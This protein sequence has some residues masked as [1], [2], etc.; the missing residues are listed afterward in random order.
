MTVTNIA[1]HY[2][3]LDAVYNTQ[4]INCPCQVFNLDE[5]GF[6]I[7]GATRSLTILIAPKTHR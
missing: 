1:T 2:G 3:R 4:G 7:R 6:G 5:M